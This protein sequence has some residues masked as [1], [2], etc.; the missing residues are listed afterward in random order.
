MCLRGSIT[1]ETNLDANET[2]IISLEGNDT[3]QDYYDITIPM[4]ASG[5]DANAYI[6]DEDWLVTKIQEVHVVPGSATLTVTVKKCTGSKHRMPA[7]RCI[8]L[9]SPSMGRLYSCSCCTIIYIYRPDSCGRRTDSLGLFR[10]CNS[11]LR[12]SITIKMKTV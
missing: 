3:A 7:H 4:N 5:G 6:A 1:L 8:I 9:P 2:R 10:R 11:V 12:G